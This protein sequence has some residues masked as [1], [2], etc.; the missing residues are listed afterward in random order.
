MLVRTGTGATDEFVCPKPRKRRWTLLSNCSF[1]PHSVVSGSACVRV[2]GVPRSV[3]RAAAVKPR[4]SVPATSSGYPAVCTPSPHTVSAPRE[5]S[6]S[7]RTPDT[8]R[9]FSYF[10][11]FYALRESQTHPVRPGARTVHNGFCPPCPSH[12]QK[13]K[14]KAKRSEERQEW[15]SSG[16]GD[17][18]Q[19]HQIQ[20]RDNVRLADALVSTQI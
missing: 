3:S 1:E 15:Y 9:Y 5:R 12:G 19:N 20:H 2:C 17:F 16:F 6:R 4:A 7:F 18:T 8:D 13:Y 11:S 10:A 14:K